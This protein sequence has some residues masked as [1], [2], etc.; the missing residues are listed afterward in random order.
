MVMSLQEQTMSKIHG[1]EPWQK[2]PLAFKYSI[3][4]WRAGEKCHHNGKIISKSTQ[5][6]I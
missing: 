3:S 1:G 4:I 6:K 2:A 5:E